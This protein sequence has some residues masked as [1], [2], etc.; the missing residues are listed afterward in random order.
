MDLLSVLLP[1][2]CAVCGRPGADA[3]CPDCAGALVL[4]GPTGCARCGA[5]GPWPVSRCVECTG[6]RLA[7]TTARAA[8]AYDHHARV[9]V[10]SWKEGGR[11]RLARTLAALVTGTLARPDVEA[12]VWVP[13]DRARTRERGHVPSQRFATALG[14]DWGLSVAGLLVRTREV[15]RQASLALADRRRNVRGAFAARGDA[16]RSVCLV[17]DV[18]T[19]GSTA[20]ACASALRSAGARR[21]EVVCLAR[22]VR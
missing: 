6:R 5:P 10:R 9:L 1:Q 22:V 13:G 19:T 16:P 11:R 3:L 12:L 2:N 15:P 20:N 17:D 14:V 21:V 4:L 18:Y 8:I 7:F